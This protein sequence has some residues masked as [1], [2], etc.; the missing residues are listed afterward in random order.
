[1]NKQDCKKEGWVLSDDDGRDLIISSSAKEIVDKGAT[2]ECQ[3]DV[4]SLVDKKYR[5]KQYFPNIPHIEFFDSLSNEKLKA[6]ISK[7]EHY[8]GL[9]CSGEAEYEKTVFY[10]FSEKKYLR[11]YDEVMNNMIEGHFPIEVNLRSEGRKVYT[12]LPNEYDRYSADIDYFDVPVAIKISPLERGE[13]CMRNADVI[14]G[15]KHY[16]WTME[17]NE[18]MGSTV[19]EVIILMWEGK[20]GIPLTKKKSQ[21]K[22]R[23]EREYERRVEKVRFCADL[24]SS[25]AMNEMG[26]LFHN[27]RGVEQD[28]TEA[29]SWYRQAAELGC[30]D[31]MVNI[32]IL[33]D[34]GQGVVKDHEEATS[35][36]KKAAEL[37]DTWALKNVNFYFNGQRTKPNFKD[38]ILWYKKAADVGD[39]DAMIN[40]GILFEYGGNGVTRD[41]E[42]AKFWYT[43]A[44]NLGNTDALYRLGALHMDFSKG[45]KEEA[46]QWL[47]KAAELSDTDAMYRLSAFYMGSA[48]RGGYDYKEAMVWFRKAADLGDAEAMRQISYIYSNGLGVKQDTQESLSWRKK[49]ADL[50]DTLAMLF[51][52]VFYFIEENVYWH[53]KAADLGDT[54]AMVQLCYNFEEGSNGAERDYKEAM[55]WYARAVNIDYSKWVFD[56]RMGPI[57]F[58]EETGQESISLL[59][60]SAELGNASAMAGIGTLYAYGIC[61][62]RDYKEAMSWYKK[63]ADL[64]NV[65]KLDE[66]GMLYE[67]G[68][69]GIEQDYGEAMYWYLKHLKNSR[70][71]LRQQR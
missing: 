12:I 45:N 30:T 18:Y 68:G 46:V 70:S 5:I 57:I 54:N 69:Y 29:M 31:A 26:I 9:N 61:V 63:A 3:W 55:S 27:G 51:L 36:Y 17:D 22:N 13:R 25:G 10:L 7:I 42:E 62:K 41:F 20:I 65:N 15:D 67:R 43:R 23:T 44:A 2:V 1:M 38:I 24:G 40:T 52:G 48:E 64:G 39:I 53:R 58:N 59:R 21:K 6:V 34:N 66:I 49:A 50:G 60:K 14:V 8:S 19:A 35:W 4:M 16:E 56:Y 11:Y 32:G 33:Y 37:G 47:I 28:F 71:R